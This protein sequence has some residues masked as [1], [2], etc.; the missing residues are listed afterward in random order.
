MQVGRNNKIY[1]TNFR[2]DKQ[3]DIARTRTYII[4]LQKS[5]RPKSNWVARFAL[6]LDKKSYF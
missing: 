2:A 1:Q 4:T 5:G 3:K 6:R